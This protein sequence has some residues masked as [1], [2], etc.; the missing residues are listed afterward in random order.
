[1]TLKASFIVYCQKR[2]TSINAS[3]YDV[4]FLPQIGARNVQLR[5]VLDTFV[6][7]KALLAGWA[8]SK[9]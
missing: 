2:D 6:E 8:R 5:L 4:P 3:D 9:V 1:M 7:C